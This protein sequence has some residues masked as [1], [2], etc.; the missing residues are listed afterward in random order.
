MW[1]T[2]SKKLGLPLPSWVLLLW[3]ELDMIYPVGAS[4]SYKSQPHWTCMQPG[5]LDKVLWFDVRSRHACHMCVMLVLP[6]VS[7]ARSAV[8]VSD[9]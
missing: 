9:R 6:G 3:L 4:A 2:K 1:R 5:A 7:P 8:T